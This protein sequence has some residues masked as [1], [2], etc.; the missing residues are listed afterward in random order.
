MAEQRSALAVL[1]GMT[2]DEMGRFE[3]KVHVEPNTGCWLWTASAEPLGYGRM[4]VFRGGRWRVRK[5]HQ[6]SHE[7]FKGPVPDG[8]VIDHLCR[9]PA[10]CNPDHLEAVTQAE[11]LRRGGYALWQ[12]SKTHCPQG[13]PY[14]EANTRLY[15]N[16]RM[17]RACRNAA[18][19]ARQRR[20]R[21]ERHATQG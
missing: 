16:R 9:T 3:R 2:P 20:L 15:K 6:L 14:D 10:C 5:A 11:N 19:R 7:H 4:T 18:E 13:H 1:C 12:R 17:C 8:L 21:Q